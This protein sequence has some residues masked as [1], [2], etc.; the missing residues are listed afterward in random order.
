MSKSTRG[1]F[2]VYFYSGQNVNLD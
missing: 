1:Y 2:K